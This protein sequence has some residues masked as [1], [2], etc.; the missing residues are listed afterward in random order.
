[1]VIVVRKKMCK[2]CGK[3]INDNDICCV[4]PIRRSDKQRESDK[5][6]R[7]RRWAK[8]R[9][10]VLK[11]DN[12][13]CQRCLIKFGITN[14]EDLTVHHIKSRKDYPELFHELSNLVCLCRTC[15]N[16]LEAKEYNHELDFDFKIEE[17]E[18]LL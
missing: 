11:R 1:M 14:T 9:Q 5:E 13:L 15:N 4:T 3:I 2:H 8:T 18:I 6:L 12:Y 16:Q 17:Y 10:T 7:T